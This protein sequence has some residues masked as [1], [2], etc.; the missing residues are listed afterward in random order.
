MS[1]VFPCNRDLFYLEMTSGG[2]FIPILICIATQETCPI[3]WVMEIFSFINLL[4]IEHIKLGLG[5][6]VAI[7][8]GKQSLKEEKQHKVVLEDLRDI[9]IGGAGFGLLFVSDGC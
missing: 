4:R 2:Y 7:N 5:K 6:M 9:S 8:Y 1:I 3:A